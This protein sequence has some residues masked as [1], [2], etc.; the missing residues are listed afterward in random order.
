[1]RLFLKSI[2]LSK[3]SMPY[4]LMGISPKGMAS[5]FLFLQSLSTHLI[6]CVPTL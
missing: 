3:F 4:S 2:Y 1:M 6:P 5:N